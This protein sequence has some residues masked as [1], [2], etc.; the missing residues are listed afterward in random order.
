MSVETPL[1]VRPDIF[2]ECKD[3]HLV[4]DLIDN[5][6]KYKPS[7][8]HISAKTNKISIT[9]TQKSG[10]ILMQHEVEMQ[11]QYT[12]NGSVLNVPGGNIKPEPVDCPHRE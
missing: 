9:C 2:P 3:C 11:I 6:T 1:I 12:K 7:L 4:S 5:W 8:E 10:K